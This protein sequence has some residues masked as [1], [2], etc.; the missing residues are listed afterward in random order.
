MRGV[1]CAGLSLAAC[2]LL[3]LYSYRKVGGYTGDT[4]GATCELV[5]T[6]TLLVW[7]AG[8]SGRQAL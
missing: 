3:A 1:L 4:L 8:L 6:A 2:L 7:V 5:E